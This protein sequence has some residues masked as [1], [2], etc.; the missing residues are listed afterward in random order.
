MIRRGN[1]SQGLWFLDRVET[2]MVWREWKKLSTPEKVKR[3]GEGALR[4]RSGQAS[5]TE[6]QPRGMQDPY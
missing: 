1:P 3:A 4:L 6:G 5:A 2:A